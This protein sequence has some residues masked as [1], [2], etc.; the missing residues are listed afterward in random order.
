VWGQV[1][2][3]W[4]ANVAP[5]QPAAPSSASTKA[6]TVTAT[7]TATASALP[8]AKVPDITTSVTAGATAPTP[9][10]ATTPTP[11]ET[12]AASKS[13]PV[14][15]KTSKKTEEKPKI[16]PRVME[17]KGRIEEDLDR[18]NLSDKVQVR[19]AGNSLILT[20][21]LGPIV[22]QRLM[23]RLEQLPSDVKIEDNIEYAPDA[24]NETVPDLNGKCLLVV[25]SNPPGAEVYVDGRPT[26][27]VTPARVRLEPGQHAVKLM[28]AGHEAV[29]RVIE[30]QADKIVRLNPPIN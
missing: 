16:D 9:T 8:P 30:A 18:S 3:R 17:M 23:R 4:S 6:P 12:A 15:P 25:N 11:T 22:H 2:A 21:R 20:G 27:L 29:R 7:V 13:Q 26:G 28:L 10:P 5:P 14:V 24:A 19:A 1:R